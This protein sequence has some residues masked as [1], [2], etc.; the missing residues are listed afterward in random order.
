[1]SASWIW[2]SLLISAVVALVTC[3]SFYLFF[4]IHQEL[5]FQ[6]ARA[7][8][9]GGATFVLTAIVAMIFFRTRTKR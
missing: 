8:E 2:R 3:G 5:D 4:R 6:P 9:L 7:W 1:M